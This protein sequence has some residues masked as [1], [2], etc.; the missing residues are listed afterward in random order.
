MNWTE[1]QKEV[2]DSNGSDLLVAAAAGS[3]KTAVL[4]ERIKRLII[5][6][7][8]DIDR[9]LVVTF[10]R[11]A[12]S[13]MKEKIADALISQAGD[14][15]D[16]A[17]EMQIQLEKLGEAWISTFDS[18]IIDIV[19]QYFYIIDIEPDLEICSPEDAALINIESMDETFD[20]L[21]AEGR[22]EVI[23]FLDAYS[24]PKSDKMLKEKLM[25]L[26]D[27]LRAMPGCLDWLEES[28]FSKV[29]CVV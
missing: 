28:I 4:V 20:R 5:E 14:D 7:K 15:P 2:I 1:K 25:D 13:E 12:A 17:E 16:T 29:W 24:S 26:Y 8:K 21:Y 19:R 18:F 23:R 27:S 11:A 9:F 6:E 22:E 10:T 3:G